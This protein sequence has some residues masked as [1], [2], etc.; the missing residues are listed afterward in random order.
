MGVI[1]FLLMVTC[2][3]FVVGTIKTAAMFLAGGIC[4]YFLY[5]W[6]MSE[7]EN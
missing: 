3:G 1:L 2:I 7:E 5:T 6:L 4:L